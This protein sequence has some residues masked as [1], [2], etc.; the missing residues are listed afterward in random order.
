MSKEKIKFEVFKNITVPIVKGHPYPDI[1]KVFDP[2]ELVK[3]KEICGNCKRLRIWKNFQD[4]YYSQCK[5]DKSPEFGEAGYIG[6]EVPATCV[7]I[8][9]YKRLKKF[10]GLV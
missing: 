4:K 1:R 8:N 9:K 6:T 10:E 5:Y 7:C 3:I 2:P